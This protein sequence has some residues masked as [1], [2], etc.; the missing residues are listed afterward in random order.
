M[1]G[2]DELIRMLQYQLGLE[3]FAGIQYGEYLGEIR[4]PQLRAT[5]EKI[6]SDEK[7][8][9]KI[10]SEMISLVLA[11]DKPVNQADGKKINLCQDIFS[12]ADNAIL[13]SGPEKYVHEAINLII[14][15][16]HDRKIIYVSYNKIPKYTKSILDQRGL[17]KDGAVFI[18]CTNSEDTRE[19]TIRPE[20]LGDIASSI[21]EYAEKAKNPLVV[22]DT[23]SGMTIYHD[24][25]SIVQFVGML[26]DE[27][28]G[29][30]Y[31][32]LWV[33]VKGSASDELKSQIMSLCDKAH[34]VD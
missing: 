10:V 32:I 15:C 21:Q 28:R 2:K 18:N 31:K 29:K 19:I 12:L 13:V 34:I 11:Y 6:I 7:R 25:K 27:S 5:L 3:K 33:W 23:L 14:S 4:D 16:S 30:G 24:D 22:V 8:H 1:T 20:L 17:D 26:N 9:E